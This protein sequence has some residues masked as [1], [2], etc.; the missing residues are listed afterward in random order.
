ML[1]AGELANSIV[2]ALSARGVQSLTVVNR[3]A[4]RAQDLLAQLGFN[5]PS[6]RALPYE[7]LDECLLTADLVISATASAGFVLTPDDMLRL[8]PQRK[9][10][11]LILIDL[12]LPRDIHPAVREFDGVLLYDLE[13]LERAFEPRMGTRTGEPEAEKI[14]LAEVRACCKRLIAGGASPD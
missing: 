10:R 13:D 11:K 2:R 5:A 9:G 8:A 7:E 3:T 14:V 12:A 4:S 1:G 6:Y